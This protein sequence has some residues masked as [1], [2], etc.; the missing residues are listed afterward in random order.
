VSFSERFNANDVYE[1]C[2]LMIKKKTLNVY[3]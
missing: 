3:K 2:S 1:K